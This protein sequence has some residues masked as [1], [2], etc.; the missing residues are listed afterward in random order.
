MNER[1]F[2]VTAERST[3]VEIARGTPWVLCVCI[4]LNLTYG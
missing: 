2:F 1:Q 3:S 4:I